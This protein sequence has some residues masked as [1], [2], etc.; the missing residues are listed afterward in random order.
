VTTTALPDDKALQDLEQK[1][2]PEMRFR[3]LTAAAATVVGGLLILLSVFH[4]YTAGFGLLQEV[5]HRGV[6]LA[7]VLGLIFL[8]F[9]HRKALLEKAAQHRI[10]APGNVPWFDWLLAI[11]VAASVLYIPYIFEDLTFRVGNPLTI[12]V[13]M[14][15]IL[16]IALLEATR[17]S[18]GW[19][20]PIIAILFMAYALAGPVFPGLLKHAGASWTQLI[21]HQYLTSQG[22]YGVAVGVVATYVFHFVLFGVLAT[23]IGLGQLFL[24]LGLLHFHPHHPHHHHHHQCVRYHL[25]L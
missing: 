20:L 22:V 8:V 23:R 12:D 5:T 4:F 17:R 6:H 2:D 7:F 14:G 13:V 3:P 10:T 25:P 19:P 21:N 15:S 24:D 9:P 18:M 11:A 1:Y 16:I